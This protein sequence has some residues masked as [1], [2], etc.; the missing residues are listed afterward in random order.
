M[1]Y[2]DRFLQFPVITPID[3]ASLPSFKSSC[4]AVVVGYTGLEDPVSTAQ[5]ESLAKSMHPELVFGV[6]GDAALAQAEGVKTP[7]IVVYNNAADERGA[8]PIT[9][10]LDELKGKIR[11][12]A[13]PLIVDL[14]PEIHEDLLDV[15]KCSASTILSDRAY[16]WT[17]LLHTSS[18]S[19][20]AQ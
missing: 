11:K 13:L 8:L 17:H 10:D 7:A 14:Y 15:S 20:T 3:A 16:R 2:V 4:D 19:Q 18:P 12:A 1:S 6:T 9:G 5:F